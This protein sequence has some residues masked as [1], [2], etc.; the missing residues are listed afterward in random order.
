MLVFKTRAISH[1]ATLPW[2]GIQESNL[3]QELQ[4]LLCYHYTNPHQTT[5]FLKNYKT[6][7]PLDF[8]LRGFCKINLY[9]TYFTKPSRSYSMAANCGREGVPVHPQLRE[10]LFF[11][12]VFTAIVFILEVYYT[13]GLMSSYFLTCFFYLAKLYL[14]F[15][16]LSNY[17][18]FIALVVRVDGIEPSSRSG[19]F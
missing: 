5:K 3:Y 10:R 1:S 4:R 16:L 17:F 11:N 2:Q 6:K 12:T 14:R 9:L 7:N 18:S 8:H 13:F 15:T 19:R